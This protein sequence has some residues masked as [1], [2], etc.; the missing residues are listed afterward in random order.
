VGIAPTAGRF[1]ADGPLERRT[2]GTSGEWSKT[3]PT[4]EPGIGMGED[5]IT[6]TW[7]EYGNMQGVSNR[8]RVKKMV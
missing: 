1:L 4:K 3:S 6:E 5:M 2:R 7:K 8:R